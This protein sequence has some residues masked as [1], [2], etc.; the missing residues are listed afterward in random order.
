[1]RWRIPGIIFHLKTLISYK[2]FHIVIKTIVEEYHFNI[3]E[4]QDKYYFKKKVKEYFPQFT[5]E[6]IFSA[7]ESYNKNNS[8]YLRRQRSLQVLSEKLYNGVLSCYEGRITRISKVL[9][10]PE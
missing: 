6:I 10:F 4:Y 3:E 9:P 5:D 2:N 7:I 1:M 8:S